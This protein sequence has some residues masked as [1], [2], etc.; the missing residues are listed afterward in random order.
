M[1]DPDIPHWFVAHTKPRC[2]KKFATL[3]GAEKFPHELPLVESVRN[4]GR[5]T[6]RHTV[7]VFPGYVFVQFPPG[8]KNRCYQGDYLVRLIEVEDE[9]RFL[10][11][12]EDVR[13][14]M[15][16]GHEVLLHPLMR[17]G[18]K[19]RIVAGPLRGLEGIIDNPDDPKG[20]VLAVDVLQ[21]GILVRIPFRDLKPLR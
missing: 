12:L 19:A 6:K 10:G 3:L 9:A 16:S 7:P 13:R 2:E 1:L 15:A 5:H 17:K 11:Q 14:L 20:I 8:L 18:V 21:Q 4:Y